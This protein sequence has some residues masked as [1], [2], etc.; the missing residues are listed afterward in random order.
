MH[1]GQR[2]EAKCC[3]AA[4]EGSGAP[5]KERGH[6][7]RTR[8]AGALR[9]AGGVGHRQRRWGQLSGFWWLVG[10]SKAGGR[11]G[12]AV[13]RRAGDRYYRAEDREGPLAFQGTLTTALLDWQAG[14]C[15][16]R[17]TAAA[18]WQQ[19]GSRGVG[20]GKSRWA[21]GK[22]C[23]RQGSMRIAAMQKRQARGG[24]RGVQHSKG[25]SREGRGRGRRRW[26]DSQAGWAR[27]RGAG[28]DRSAGM[29]WHGRKRGQL[30]DSKCA[31]AGKWRARGIREGPHKGRVRCACCCARQLRAPRTRAERRVRV[32]GAMAARA[33][34][35]CVL[36][37]AAPREHV[38]QWANA[39]WARAHPGRG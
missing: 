14:M 5:G 34:A 33:G 37:S 11:Q 36:G 32:Q 3:R 21:R 18:T 2:R 28:R 20:R 24:P 26:E 39:P 30:S 9:R 38:G 19:R 1:G 23:A 22:G 25:A 7:Q 12:C 10:R 15:C 27:Q 16:L 35:L 17:H 31:V 4:A 8:A 6:P 13:A 29:G